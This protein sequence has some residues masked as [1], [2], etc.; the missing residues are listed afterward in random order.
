MGSVSAEQKPNAFRLGYRPALD[1]LRGAAL[2]VVMLYHYSVPFAHGGFLGVDAFFVLSGFLITSLLVEEWLTTGR[3]S[4]KRFYL[5]RGLRLLPALFAMLGGTTVVALSVATPDA[6]A[7]IWRGTAGTLLY[8][9]NWQKFLDSPSVGMLGHTW[10]LSLEEQF[11]VLW[12]PLLLLLLCRVKLRWVT[13]AAA[14]TALASAGLRAAQLLAGA[15]TYRLF[16]GTH[17][18][19]DSLLIGCA[20]ALAVQCGLVPRGRWPA[21]ARLLAGII[22][23]LA[24][25][26]PLWTVATPDD[27]PLYLFGFLL[28]ACG[29]AALIASMV[30]GQ[31]HNLVLESSP[32]VWIGARSY[33]IYLW[34]LPV[35]ETL[36]MLGLGHLP[37]APLVV[38]NVTI[39]L[40]LAALSYRWVELP[41]L[42]LKRRFGAL[43]EPAAPEPRRLAVPSAQP[44]PAYGWVRID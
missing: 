13:L 36:D 19:I 23:P 43:S 10:S 14:A 40:A 39:S 28:F 44:S 6:R 16:N 9:A 4:F 15:S 25:C 35:R 7:A 17:T 27:R 20:A 30:A 34:H 32:L 2:L 38:L 29:V 18:R 3:L 21:P 41:A 24:L 22:L 33:S 31:M 5:R 11:Y 12:P 42:A 37:L 1:G 26:V 8:V